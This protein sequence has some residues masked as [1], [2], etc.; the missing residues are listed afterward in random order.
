MEKIAVFAYKGM[1]GSTICKYYQEK[2][3]EVMGWSRSNR[4]H[5]IEEINEKADYVFIC[6]PTPFDWEK[7]EYDISAVISTLKLLELKTTAKVVLKSTIVPGTTGKL[8]EEFP[9][10]NLFFNPEF[11]SEAT[12]YQDFVNPDRQIVGYA[13]NNVKAYEMATEVLH[14]LPMSPYDVIMTSTEAEIVKYVNN[15]HGSLMVI[16]ANL[17][18]DICQRV[19]GDYNR[20]RKA[21]QASKWVGS[22]MGRM[23]WEVLHGGFRGY[24][25]KC[26][27]KDMNSLLNW[28]KKEKINCEIVEGMI[29][30]NRRLLSS[31][32]LTEPQVEKYSNRV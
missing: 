27:P 1:V 4:T 28:L 24:G 17:I 30:A 11:L 7:N 9:K 6:V 25:G 18:F 5:E 3:Y 13:P 19:G 29:N 15:F 26:F 23:Y 14:F 21:S 20:V 22:P 8:Q 12:A 10:L 16:F 2:G 31:Q 32:G